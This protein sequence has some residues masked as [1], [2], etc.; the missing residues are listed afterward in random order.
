MHVG[1]RNEVVTV[2]GWLNPGAE[3]TN[4]TQQADLPHAKPTS[5][6]KDSYLGIITSRNRPEYVT[7][8][9]SVCIW[10]HIR[11]HQRLRV[12]QR[13]Q[14]SLKMKYQHVLRT[15]CNNVH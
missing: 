13:R 9:R 1:V 15:A 11:F 7:L 4:R 6:R 8:V 3:G 14:F 5:F 12:K 10:G 2:L